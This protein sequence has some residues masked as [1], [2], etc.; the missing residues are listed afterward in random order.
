VEGHASNE[1]EDDYNLRLSEKRAKAV[2]DHLI[3]KGKVA[4][5][6]LTSEGFGETQPIHSNDSES[7]REAIRRVEFTILDQEA[8]DTGT[9]G[10]K[11]LSCEDKGGTERAFLHAEREM[12]TRI[13]YK[14]THHVR[15][16]QGIMIGHG[17]TEK[18]EHDETVEVGNNRKV[19]I[20]ANDKLDVA[21]SLK[22]KA[23]TTI[24]IEANTS[25]TLKVGASTIKMD[26]ASI[27]LESPQITVT[28]NATAKLTS[29]L[30][31][32]EGTGILTVTGGLVKIN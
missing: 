23:G 4:K 10:V 29:P 20:D 3:K 26:P 22:V 17:R 13:R 7:G 25:I 8:V 2:M 5:Q 21:Q 24:D 6:R 14:D 32:V 12:K 11:E 1:G 19:K 18:V 15:Y 28:G 27:K 31:T 16:D 9:R 30:S